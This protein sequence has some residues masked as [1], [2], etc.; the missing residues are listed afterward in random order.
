V[1]RILICDDSNVM[2]TLL[3]RKLTDGGH[4]V[5][6]KGKDG[7]EGIKLFSEH[8]PD[9]VLLDITMPNRD[10]REC[11]KE[12]LHQHPAAKAIMLS[13]LKD[14]A[15]IQE[16]LKVGAKAFVS[17]SNLHNDDEFKKEILNVILQVLKT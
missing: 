8:K 10:G 12:I 4:T 3:E 16:C 11:L 13:A 14:D 9:V 7:D 1:A 5:V 15:V 2:R 17:K 6:A